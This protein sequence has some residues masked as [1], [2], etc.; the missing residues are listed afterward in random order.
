MEHPDKQDLLSNIYFCLG[1]IAA[2]TNDHN[3]SRRYKELSFQLQYGISQD[4]GIY[5]ERLALAYS[6]R[7]IS[8]IQDGRLDEAVLDLKREKEIRVSL[9]TYVP[10]SREANLGLAYLLQGKLNQCE[11]LL[12]NSLETRWRTLGKNDKES[13]R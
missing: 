2:D 5:S 4:T 3:L 1:A 13:F 7:S 11:I 8:R 10:L 12:I 9:G 6:E